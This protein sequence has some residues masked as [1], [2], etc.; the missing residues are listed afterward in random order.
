MERWVCIETADRKQPAWCEHR[1]NRRKAFGSVN[2]KHA[3]LELST[4]QNL[5]AYIAIFSRKKRNRTSFQQLN[6]YGFTS[7]E[8][9]GSKMTSVTGALPGTIMLPNLYDHG[10]VL[11]L[12][13]RR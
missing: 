2:V 3:R 7:G 12:S 5:Q 9:P 10:S 1:E 4:H 8:R 13:T 11:F 6:T